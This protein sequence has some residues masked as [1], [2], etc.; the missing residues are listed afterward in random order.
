VFLVLFHLVKC[1]AEE[2]YSSWVHFW[3]PQLPRG[4]WFFT[5]NRYIYCPNFYHVYFWG[6][7]AFRA[8]QNSLRCVHNFA[9]FSN[10]P[11]V[12][13]LW[14]HFLGDVLDAT[15]VIPVRLRNYRK[16]TAELRRFVH[17]KSHHPRNVFKGVVH[18][19]CLRIRRNCEHNA[20][21]FEALEML[22][23]PRNRHGKNLG[24]K[25]IDF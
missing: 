2:K 3:D 7:L 1:V 25:Y 19:E 24:N 22:E 15:Q 16:P 5:R 23:Y 8:P 18:G 12:Q 11:R 6:T 14:I 21:Y 13:P 9:G 17:G 4:W 20:D 10:T